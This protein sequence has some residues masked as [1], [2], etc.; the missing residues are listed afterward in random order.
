MSVTDKLLSNAESY[1]AS[2]DKASLPMPPGLQVPSLPA[3][4]PGS[5]RTGSSV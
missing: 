5:I 1:A 3:W 4:T 2:Y